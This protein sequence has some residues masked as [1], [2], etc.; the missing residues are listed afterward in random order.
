MRAVLILF[1]ILSFVWSVQSLTIDEIGLTPERC[2]AIR[3][4][5]KTFGFIPCPCKLNT[6]KVTAVPCFPNCCPR[7]DSFEG[8]RCHI[9][10]KL[11]WTVYEQQVCAERP[12][13]EYLSDN[14]NCFYRGNTPQVNGV[15]V[16]PGLTNLAFELSILPE[17]LCNNLYVAKCKTSRDPFPAQDFRLNTTDP[18]PKQCWLSC[19][20]TP[21]AP[22][23]EASCLYHKGETRS[24]VRS[25]TIQ[26]KIKPGDYALVC[27]TLVKGE[28]VGS[29][30]YQNA[31]S[32]IAFKVKSH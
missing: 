18:V 9:E 7:T 2:A 17:H 25:W 21:L 32:T 31:Y 22:C 4:D 10:N 13:A 29:S 11:S 1:G 23:T 3:A 14:P 28:A 15:Q 19:P 8:D 16:A 12:P 24:V 6:G 27:S 26:D 5:V 20:P 30:L